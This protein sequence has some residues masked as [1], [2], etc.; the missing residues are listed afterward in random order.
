MLWHT[1]CTHYILCLWSATASFW[2]RVV[3][4]PVPGRGTVTGR[5]CK[6]FVIVVVVL[7]V[8]DIVELAEDVLCIFTTGRNTCRCH[9]PFELWR[10]LL[11]AICSAQH[12]SCLYLHSSAFAAF[13][14]LEFQLTSAILSD[15]KENPFFS[16]YVLKGSRKKKR[17]FMVRIKIEKSQWAK[18]A[19]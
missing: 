17:Y 5:V 3:K 8:V 12:V 1:C 6:V 15:L 7:V 10:N 18:C 13:S 11:F 14:K 19:T 9:I 2:W 4:H 16:K